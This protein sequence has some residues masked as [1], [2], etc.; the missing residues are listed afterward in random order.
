MKRQEGFSLLEIMVVLGVFL[1]IT[2]MVFELLLVAQQRY[3]AETEFLDSFQSA[4]IG[5]D[6]MVRDVHTAGYPPINTVPAAVAAANPNL[7]AEPFAWGVNYPA[8]P[9]SVLASCDNPGGPRRFDVIIESDVDPESN[10]G[11]EWVRYQL[12]GG[13]LFMRGVTPKVVGANPV[14]AMNVAGVM[15]PYVDNVMN[16]ATAGEMAAIRA[17]Y[18]AMF[19]GNAAVPVFQFACG[20]PAGP[21]NALHSSRDITEITITLIVQSPNPDPRTR[22]MRV[23]TLTG[24]A[25]RINPS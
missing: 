16:N 1:I 20:T 15:V 12:R 21:C 18:P 6:Q 14:A 17:S 22:Q 9:C 2:G 5:L 11:V 3:K 19:P 13:N 7:V 23:V 25:R 4:R 8:I 24:L 10:N